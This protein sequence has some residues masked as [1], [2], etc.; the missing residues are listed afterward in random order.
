MLVYVL[1]TFT[2]QIDEE[3]LGNKNPS[4][5]S[6][7]VSMMDECHV[8]VFRTQRVETGPLTRVDQ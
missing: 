5:L 6:M 4:I 1:V 7:M 8:K 2:L 3:V